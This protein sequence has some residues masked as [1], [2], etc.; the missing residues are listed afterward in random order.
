MKPSVPVSLSSKPGSPNQDRTPAYRS[1]RH[2][3]KALDKIIGQR[4][5]HCAKVVPKPLP[6]AAAMI[7]WQRKQVARAIDNCLMLGCG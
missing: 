7:G 3:A 1:V 5:M 6:K 4:P 2:A